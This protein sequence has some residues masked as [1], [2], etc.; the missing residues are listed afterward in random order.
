VSFVNCFDAA[1]FGRLAYLTV[2]QRRRLRSVLAA[3][4]D[5]G[6]IPRGARREL[7]RLRGCRAGLTAGEG[8]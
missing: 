4:H 1:T 2:Q 6:F 7:R 5:Y 3:L 8:R